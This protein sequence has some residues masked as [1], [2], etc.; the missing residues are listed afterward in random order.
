MLRLRG[1]SVGFKRLDISRSRS[2]PLIQIADLVAG[3]ILHRDT[4]NESSAYDL[5]AR[6]IRYLTEIF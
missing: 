2:E 1:M 5:I 4:Y 6:K 3:S